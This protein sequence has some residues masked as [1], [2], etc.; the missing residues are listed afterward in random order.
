MNA[1]PCTPLN[2]SEVILLNTL[3]EDGR[4]SY[5]FMRVR[6]MEKLRLSAKLRKHDIVTLDDYGTVLKSGWG[7]APEKWCRHFGIS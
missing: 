6:R 5:Y 1:A 4:R 3:H 2:F 7:K